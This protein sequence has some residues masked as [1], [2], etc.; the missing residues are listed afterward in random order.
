MPII[1]RYLIAELR[2][3]LAMVGGIL[4]LIFASY[5][6]A[7]Y[8][9]DAV[10]QTLGGVVLVEL[11]ML[12]TLI[13]L[14]I[15]IPI[16]LYIA[17]V[18][19][20]G[21]LY[22]DQ[23]MTVLNASGVGPFRVYRAVLLLALPVA[24]LVGLLSLYGRPWAYGQAYWLEARA[25]A[26]IHLDRMRGGRFQTDPDTGRTILARKVDARAGVL[27][28]VLIYTHDTGRSQVIVADTARQ[29]P[30][31]RGEEPVLLLRDGVAYSLDRHGGDDRIVRFHELTLH[32]DQ[33][34]PVVGY[35]RKAAATAAL[36]AS[37]QP[38]DVAELQWRLSR[39]L[40]TLLLA[41]LAVP[42]SRSAPRRGRYSKMFLAVLV[43]ALVYNA[44]GLARSWVEQGAVGPVPGIWWVSGLMFAALLLLLPTRRVRSR[45]LR[46]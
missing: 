40:T 5:S 34:A 14:E 2:R 44:S 23:E 45:T 18:V 28:D 37:Q 19:G 30:V 11:V 41:L 22:H 31:V 24:L 26:E 33:P 38:S 35:K 3:P 32:L 4:I 17:V 8:L 39:P 42:L 12:K 36:A 16:A 46:R 43:Y 10:S 9:A 6:T 20:L 25:H 21:R 7:R 27:R 29:P 1:E 13:A 15:L